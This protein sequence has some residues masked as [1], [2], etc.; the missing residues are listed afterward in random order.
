MVGTEIRT[1]RAENREPWHANAQVPC[2]GIDEKLAPRLSSLFCVSG[3]AMN[4]HTLPAVLPLTFFISYRRRDLPAALLLKSE[5][6]RRF[7]FVRVMVDTEDVPWG[8]NFPDRLKRLIESSHAVIILISQGWMPENSGSPTHTD[9]VLYE[10]THCCEA[11]LLSRSENKFIEGKRAF[12]PV[13]LNCTPGFDQVVLPEALGFL[14]E[15]NGLRIDDDSWSRDVSRLLSDI[16]GQFSIQPQRE[17]SYP[18]PDPRKGSSQRVENAVLSKALS[19]DEYEGWYPDNFGTADTLHLVKT[20][21]FADFGE[22]TE[23]MRIVSE[24]CR[25]MDHH[26]DWWN[27]HRYVKVSLST[28]D[29]GQHITIF[30]LGLALFM[31]KAADTVRRRR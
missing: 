22:A 29:A 3:I 28:W 4:D 27:R 6:E 8:V 23:F 15:C 20:F 2:T 30:D 11:P 16:A 12:F 18:T 13:F 17:L 25:I 26:P 7:T 31:N 10:L 14:R 24:H 5:I 19:Y 9:W 1:G 21:E